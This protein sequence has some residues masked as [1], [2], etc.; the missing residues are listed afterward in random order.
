MVVRRARGRLLGIRQQRRACCYAVTVITGAELLPI[1][2]P[3]SLTG[4]RVCA[5]SPTSIARPR[6]RLEGF[7]PLRVGHDAGK[8]HRLEAGTTTLRGRLAMQ[9]MQKCINL[10]TVAT[11]TLVDGV[12]KL[13]LERV[14]HFCKQGWSAQDAA[15]SCALALV[16]DNRAFATLASFN[17]YI[18]SLWHC[19]RLR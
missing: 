7:S 8:A 13:A 3:I 2:P 6:I 1:S 19:G 18:Q 16:L 9:R 4:I 11:A 12:L 17:L 5:I 14:I 15:S 10:S